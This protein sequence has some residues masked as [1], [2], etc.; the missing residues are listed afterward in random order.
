LCL[1]RRSEHRAAGN[2]TVLSFMIYSFTKKRRMRRTEYLACVWG[3]EK[4][5]TV[6]GGQILIKETTWKT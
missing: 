3:R 4:L 5:Q 1:R 2:F 6:F